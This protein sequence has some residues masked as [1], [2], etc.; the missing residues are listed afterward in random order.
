MS[1]ELYT[2]SLFM[3]SGAYGLYNIH[4]RKFGTH[5]GKHG[6]ALDRGHV[7]RGQGDFSYYSLKPGSEF[8]AYCDQY[9]E[10]LK[11]QMLPYSD[12]KLLYT[13]IDVIT[14]PKLT[15]EVQ[16]YLEKEHGLNP[17]PVLHFGTP[18]HWLDRY[19][20]TG[21]YDL[22]GL[23]GLGQH[24]KP[25]HYPAWA[26]KMFMRICPKS[27]DY[28]PIVKT[29]G[30]A[31]TAWG[32]MVRWPWWSVD[33]ATWIKIAAYGWILVPPKKDGVYRFDMQPMQINISRKQTERKWKFWWRKGVKGPRQT[34]N[35]HV[36]N[37]HIY[38]K[39]AALEWLDH[40]K[41]PLGAYNKD[42]TIHERGVATH[43]VERALANLIYLKKFADSRPKWP[44]P[45]DLAGQDAT[46]L[47][48]SPQQARAGGLSQPLKAGSRRYYAGLGL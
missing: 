11:K 38:Y 16:Q 39:E 35:K 13:T 23:G 15:W 9:A 40:I 29:H 12:H 14:N 31:M 48:L 5:I 45:L 43:F 6:R 19:L 1:N 44:Y 33:S 4:V 2:R 34:R 24:V 10:D 8:R 42:N 22:I 47:E 21:R 25:H 36:D 17:V 26:D 27:N 30:F 32:L 28:L 18:V 37:A 41:V 46:G 20:D 3:D 7:K